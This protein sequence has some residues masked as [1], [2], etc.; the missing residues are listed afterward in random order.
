MNWRVKLL[1]RNTIIG[2]LST[3][4]MPNSHV[5][6]RKLVLNVMLNRSIDI[7]PPVR[8]TRPRTASNGLTEV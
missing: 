6:P 1:K 2:Y 5:P 4:W 7:L 8:L 3:I